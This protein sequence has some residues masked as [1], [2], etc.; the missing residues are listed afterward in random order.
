MDAFMVG[1]HNRFVRAMD[2]AA[3][4]IGGEFTVR[5]TDSNEGAEEIYRE[6]AVSAYLDESGIAFLDEI[7]SAMLD[8]A[9]VRGGWQWPSEGDRLRF[10]WD[11]FKELVNHQGRSLFMNRPRRGTYAVTVRSAYGRRA[12]AS[13]VS[14]CDARVVR[15]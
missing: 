7:Q 10:S 1:V 4:F 9:W 5:T 14:S 6:H 15:R 8:V 13:F 12:K 11:A 2:D 3:P